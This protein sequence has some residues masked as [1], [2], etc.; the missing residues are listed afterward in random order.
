[1]TKITALRLPASIRLRLLAGGKRGDGDSMAHIIK[2]ILMK[3]LNDG[4]GINTHAAQ[5]F[6]QNSLLNFGIA[7][8]LVMLLVV[9]LVKIGKIQ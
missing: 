5:S 4:V 9:W 8:M 3:A 6:H 2:D 7:T 1:M